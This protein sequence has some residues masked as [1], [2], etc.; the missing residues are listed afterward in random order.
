MRI[1]G[2]RKTKFL[3]AKNWRRVFKDDLR[4]VANRGEKKI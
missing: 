3:V 2:I 1:E 4:V